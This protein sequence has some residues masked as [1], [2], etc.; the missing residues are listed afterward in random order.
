[1]AQRRIAHGERVELLGVNAPPPWFYWASG[2]A[3][4][5]EGNLNEGVF[6]VHSLALALLELLPEPYCKCYRF[7]AEVRHDRKVGSNVGIYFGRREHAM[8]DGVAHA[9][10]E[11]SFDDATDWQ[12]KWPELGAESNPAELWYRQVRLGGGPRSSNDGVVADLGARFV[13]AAR[14][15]A[16][17]VWRVLEVIVTPDSIELIWDG[18]SQGKRTRPELLAKAQS[19]TDTITYS[20]PIPVDFADGGGLGLFVH[21]SAASFRKVWL[22]PLPHQ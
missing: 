19:L 1:L 11:V 7:H 9:F 5:Q 10:W 18:A 22:E 14:L 13:P 17:E 3:G 15:S 12:K 20:P 8:A 16:G 4:T 2:S 6:R 21:K